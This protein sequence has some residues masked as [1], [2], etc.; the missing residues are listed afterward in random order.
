[1]EILRGGGFS[2]RRG[3]RWAVGVGTLFVAA[4]VHVLAVRTGMLALYGGLLAW[5]LAAAWHAKRYVWAIGTVAL[6]ALAPVAAYQLLPSV[7][8]KVGLMLWNLERY[9]AGEIGQYSDT[10]RW[11][12]YEVGLAIGNRAPW[13]GCGIGDLDA[14]VDAEYARRFPDV[15][16]MLPHNQWL[17]F[18]AACGVVGLL[19]ALTA[20]FS[21]LFWEK[22][23]QDPLFAGFFLL[24][25]VSFMT[26]TAIETAVGVGLTAFFLSLL[27]AAR[28]PE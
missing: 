22:K 17:F 23:Y 5:G 12:S 16:P 20:F 28:N 9:R 15:K 10:Q 4:M 21:P 6:L 19:F 14:E 7:R 26:E 25:T 27:M 3:L 18:F 24:T 1:L 8:A 11:A 13:L 2:D